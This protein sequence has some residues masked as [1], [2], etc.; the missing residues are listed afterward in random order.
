MPTTGSTTVL[1]SAKWLSSSIL[2]FLNL[3][4]VVLYEFPYSQ[5]SPF[6]ALTSSAEVS[7]YLKW[8]TIGIGVVRSFA[9][10]A[11]Y[12]LLCNYYFYSSDGHR[13]GQETLVELMLPHQNIAY[14]TTS[15]MAKGIFKWWFLF[16]YACCHLSYPL[17]FN[18]C[19]NCLKHNRC[20][21]DTHEIY[22]WTLSSLRFSA[23]S[24]FLI[25][26]AVCCTIRL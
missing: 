20:I 6:L 2:L 4:A 25:F 10:T 3:A 14:S 9:I 21:I 15:H 16:F 11:L 7:T 23:R 12:W 1:G 19:L 8:L 22:T 13:S 26:P 5:S 18:Q 24:E 17:F